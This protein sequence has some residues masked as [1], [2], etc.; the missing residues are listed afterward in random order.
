MS[1]Q[2]FKIVTIHISAFFFLLTILIFE[3]SIQNLIEDGVIKNNL[4]HS[5]EDEI[6]FLALGISIFY[7]IKVTSILDKRKEE[8]GPENF[9][10]N[11]FIPF[12]YMLIIYF[13][14]N[15]LKSIFIL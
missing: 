7:F 11:D 3:N 5:K 8:V 14:S 10:C 2:L 12:I 6:N 1:N 13:F 15:C 4:L 9:Q